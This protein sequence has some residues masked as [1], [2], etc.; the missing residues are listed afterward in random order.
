MFVL[1]IYPDNVSAGTVSSVC[2][3]FVYI[4]VRRV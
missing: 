1:N 4:Y 2:F 3:S